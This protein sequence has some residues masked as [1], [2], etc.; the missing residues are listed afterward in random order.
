L[1]AGI[2]PPAPARGVASDTVSPDSEALPAATPTWTDWNWW[3][4]VKIDAAAVPVGRAAGRTFTAGSTTTTVAAAVA[5]AGTRRPETGARFATAD[6]A[7]RALVREPL[8]RP[9]FDRPTSAPHPCSVAPA[10]VHDASRST[11]T[12]AA[13]AVGRRRVLGGADRTARSAVGTADQRI[14]PTDPASPARE[15]GS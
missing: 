10:P 2:V 11:T 9:L 8:A 4:A 6:G 12:P 14:A 5:A 7:K 3:R 15:Q 1:L 13:P